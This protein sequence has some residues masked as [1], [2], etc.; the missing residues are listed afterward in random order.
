MKRYTVGVDFGTLSGRA[1]LLDALDG[2]VLATSVLDYPH[3]VMD[4]KLPNG[5]PLPSQFALQHPADYLDVL[6]TTVPDVLKKAGV[7]PEEVAGLCIDFTTCTLLPVYEDGTPLC[8]DPK[9]EGHPHA[10]VKLWKHHAAQAEADHINGVARTRGEDWLRVYGGK[11]S[12]EWAL[13]KILEVLNKAPEIFSDTARFYDAGDWLSYLLT[14][15][16]SCAAGFA[17][18]K[19]LWGADRGYPSN[20]FFE[21]VDPRLSGLVGTK[22]LNDVR[23]VEKTAGVLSEKGAELTGL[24]I[25][26]PLALPSL[27]SD[28]AMPALGIVEPGTLMMIIGTSGVDL[29]HSEKELDIPGI[30][31]YVRD[32]VVPGLYTYEA[33]QCGI[34]DCFDWFVKNCVPESYE[35]DARANGMSIHKYLREKAKKLRAGESGLLALDWLNGNRSTLQD[36]DLSGMVL[37]ITLSTRPE[38]IYRAL[39]EATAFGLR[40]IV[41]TFIK[42]GLEI[43]SIRASGGI[44][45]KDGMLMQIYSDVCKMPIDVMDTDQGPAHGAAIYAAVAGG[46]YTSIIEASERLS[47]GSSV[48]YTPDEKNTAAYDV[49]YAEYSRLYEYLGGENNVMKTLKKLSN[50]L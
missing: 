41:E 7:S 10:Y 32:G 27:D 21:A 42:G 28:V 33:G 34:G 3:G 16:E 35:A 17:G 47:V 26:T 6:K 15:E 13:P 50:S 31:G 37:G 22:L 48:T 39:I 49:L 8:F 40:R 1:L 9:Y 11:I 5:T 14:G 20:E 36:A 19:F 23:T 4:R 44:A 30:C 18:F 2:K 12:S 24:P 43:K 38:E 29:V 25:G 45:K 46:L